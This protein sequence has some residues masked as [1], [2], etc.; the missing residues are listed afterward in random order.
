MAMGER[1]NRRSGCGRWLAVLLAVCC[2]LSGIAGG[3]A[4][5]AAA[6]AGI[7]AYRLEDGV[8]YLSEGIQVIGYVPEELLEQIPGLIVSNALQDY[9]YEQMYELPAASRDRTEE[10]VL[11]ESLLFIGE[12]AFFGVYADRLRWPEKVTQVMDL[13]LDDSGLGEI[14]FHAGVTEY[15]RDSFYGC[16]GTAAFTVE[17]DNPA[18]KAVD[19][20]LFSRDGKILLRYP[21]MKEGTHYDVPAGVEVIWPCAFES[22]QQLQSISLP[23]GLKRIGWSAF[24][25]CVQ[26]ESVAVPLTLQEIEAYAFQ[27]CVSLSSLR[28]PAGVQVVCDTETLAI[29]NSWY[30]EP[31]KPEEYVFYNTPR[32]TG[33][34][35]WDRLKVEEKRQAEESQED[36][37]EAEPEQR[38]TPRM[39]YA[40]LNPENARDHVKI[41]PQPNANTEP[42]GSFDSGSTVTMVDYR[43]GWYQVWWRRDCDE[44]AMDGWVKQE[45]L[46]LCDNG[47]PLFQIAS[48][49]PK[50]SSVYFMNNG[51]C[52]L[53]YDQ[54]KK[55][56]PE[57]D[58]LTFIGMEG[59]WV[60]AARMDE[61]WGFSFVYLY[62]SDLLYTRQYTGDSL[63]YGIVISDDARDRLNLREEP[64]R[65]SKSIGKYFSGT[66][67]E[68]LGEEGD[69]YRV[70]VDFR[71]GWMM[72]E[73]VREVP[74]EAAPGEE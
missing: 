44:G 8:L 24:A 19:G 53:P 68:I 32:L 54:P 17:A 72:K 36:W 37:P 56:L 20:V 61:E 65:S 69:W 7:P 25:E 48:I 14:I 31:W 30:N 29:C 5:R 71:D 47:E 57:G 2:L 26:L 12:G 66:Q 55:R 52:L 46:L 41:Y 60:M 58:A 43:D 74:Q 63:R 45:E 4:S 6:E 15:S 59:Q 35:D 10:I 38:E 28:L 42:F 64:D 27:D 33:Y 9:G 39:R 62:P 11:P 67:V 40:I 49:R 3:A 16:N 50:D 51:P 73:F 21:P 1:K 70:R 23:M 34:E 22:C 13:A 18:M